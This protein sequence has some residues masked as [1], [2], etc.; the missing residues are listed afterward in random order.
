MF[1]E[2][3]PGLLLYVGK[4]IKFTWLQI[5]ENRCELS[6]MISENFEITCLKWLKH[7]TCAPIKPSVTSENF[8]FFSSLIFVSGNLALKSKEVKCYQKWLKMGLN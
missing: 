6:A 4:K 1:S 5:T 7:H 8:I 2:H 3:K